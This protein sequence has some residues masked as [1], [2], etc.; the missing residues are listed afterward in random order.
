MLSARGALELIEPT[1]STYNWPGFEFRKAAGRLS[2]QGKITT[3]IAVLELGARIV[4]VVGPA[5][6]LSMVHTQLGELLLREGNR[7]RAAE[8]ADVALRADSTNTGALLIAQRA[9]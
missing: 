8:V 6:S 7:R 2:D 1:D 3:A 4:E 5:P 9:R